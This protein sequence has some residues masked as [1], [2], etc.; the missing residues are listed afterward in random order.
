MLN[1]LKS[2]NRL[3]V[4][5]AKNPQNI[6]I[7]NLLKLQQNSYK[8]F[9]MVGEEDRSEAGI[10]KVFKSI[11]PIHD[12]QNR[13]TLD[14]IKSEVGKPKY[15]V[16]EAMVRGLTYSIPL[17]IN[18]RLTLWDLDEKT[19]EKIGVRDI[20]EQSIFIRE[21]PLMTHRTSFVVNGVERVVVNQLHRAPGVIFKEEEASTVVNKLI[22][23]G[24]IIPNRGSWIYFEYDA[25]DVL[26]VRINKR[27][28]VPVTIL[29]RALGYSKD[30]I[31]KLFYP[32][33]N[34]KVKNNKFL[35]AFKPENFTGRVEFDL[36]DEKGNVIIASGKRLTERKAKALA[37][38][39]LKFVEYPVELLMERHISN[40]IYDPESG[41]IL[42]DSLTQLDDIKLKKLLD[43]G[44][45]E[46]D[47]AND[48]A[49]GIDDSIISA[50]K[51][52]A[53]SIKLLKQTEQIDDENDLCAIR[54]YK[55]MRPG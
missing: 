41:E 25:K 9:L 20:K 40:T 19:G 36:I 39:G 2:G 33:I 47:I 7:P 6:E 1:S 26:Y 12:N 11:F 21:I 38:G 3:R 22:Y 18:V 44:F 16:S 15:N 13:F 46:I 35:Q 51:I 30:D 34:I 10:E 32:I 52:D 8:N 37:E 45:K 5:F 27:R 53:E 55:V 48:L 43:L 23:T 4:D 14:Y 29:L 42:F 54:I 50:F 49:D 17:K 31:I 28:K 24:Q